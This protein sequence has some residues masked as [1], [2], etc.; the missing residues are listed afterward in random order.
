MNKGYRLVVVI[1]CKVHYPL[2]IFYSLMLVVISIDPIETTMIADKVANPLITI[3][4]SS[5]RN[6]VIVYLKI[7]ACGRNFMIA[8][9]G[10]N[11]I[12]L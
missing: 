4:A 7:W 11:S 8:R 1:F 3:V 9:P 12:H 2:D 10:D 5:H 6:K